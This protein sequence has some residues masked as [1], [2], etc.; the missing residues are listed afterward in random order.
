VEEVADGELHGAEEATNVELWGVG[1]G[2]RW[3]VDGGGSSREESRGNKRRTPKKGKEENKIKKHY[4]PAY[5]D[6][7]SHFA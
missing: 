4:C 1:H 6:R 3:T 2:W 5:I 7:R